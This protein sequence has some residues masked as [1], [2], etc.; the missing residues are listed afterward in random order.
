MEPA[1]TAVLAPWS[2]DHELAVSTSSHHEVARAGATC[3]VASERR[4]GPR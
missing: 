2:S 4:P 3:E 1:I